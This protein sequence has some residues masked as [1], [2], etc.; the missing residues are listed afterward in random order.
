V[1]G[2]QSGAGAAK[3]ALTQ[4]SHTVDRQLVELEEKRLY[5]EILHGSGSQNPY[6]VRNQVQTIMDTYAY[7]YRDGSGLSEGLKQLRALHQTAFRHVE[8]QA[9]EYNSNF[10]N[11]LE[12]ESMFE[13]AEIVLAGGVARTESRGA[14]SRTDYPKRDD[15]NW[16]KHTL[17]YHSSDG[18]RIEYA[19]VTI[20]KYTPTERHY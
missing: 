14:H 1:F 9:K 18:P 5:D 16:L 10:I 3:Y 2:A 6:D 12:L 4:A 11:V 20:T 15:A 17:A 19:P 7:V 8:D 13:V